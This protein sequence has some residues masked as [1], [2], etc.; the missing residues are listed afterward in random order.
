MLCAGAG[1]GI[2]ENAHGNSRTSRL[3]PDSSLP[4]TPNKT[5]SGNIKVKNAE[6][7]QGWTVVT[8]F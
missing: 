5:T 6:L 4:I 2:N 1:V 3:N 7:I 8:Q